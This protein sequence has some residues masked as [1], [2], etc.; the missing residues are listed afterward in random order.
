M[1]PTMCR[2]ATSRSNPNW[3]TLACH[4]SAPRLSN[5]KATGAIGG[6]LPATGCRFNVEDEA[7]AAPST[8]SSQLPLVS[9]TAEVRE[10]NLE[11]GPALPVMVDEEYSKNCLCL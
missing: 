10:E 11:I 6:N 1:L 7:L 8:S 9:R 2:H 3:T 5:K 4:V